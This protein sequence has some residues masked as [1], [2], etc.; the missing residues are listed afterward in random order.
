MGKR[1]QII[2]K[3]DGKIIEKYEDDLEKAL[4]IMDENKNKSSYVIVNDTKENVEIDRI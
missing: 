1:Y 2:I 4:E 3:I